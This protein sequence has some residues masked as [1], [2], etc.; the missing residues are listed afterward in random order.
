MKNK[1][2]KKNYRNS[3]KVILIFSSM[4]FFVLAVT[5]LIVGVLMYLIFQRDTLNITSAET[6]GSM[7]IFFLVASIILGTVIAA[8]TAR[9]FLKNIDNIIEGMNDL[10]SGNYEVRV[11]AVQSGMTKELID[12]FNLLADELENTKTLRSDFVNDFAHEFKTPIVSL[13]GFAKLLKNPNLTDEERTEYLKIIEEEAN[14]LSVMSTNS[15]NLT[16]VEKQ[17]ILTEKTQ[18]NLSEQIRNCV[19]LLE[20]KWSEKNL[21]L[22][23]DLEEISVFANEEMLKQ[24]F[25][26]LIDNAVKF[27]YENK[28]LKLKLYKKE[29]KVVFSIR[30]YGLAISD[31]DKEKIFT[32]FYR[33]ENSMGI[34][35]TGVGLAIVKKIVELHK[36]EILLHNESDFTEFEVAIPSFE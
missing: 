2:K 28:E 5:M 22:D 20:K 16:R 3:S 10:A 1:V 19:L 23:L 13:L 12:T 29:D 14:R 17:T 33:A 9:I 34:E 8:T 31:A 26:N 24:V 15:L 7:V 35:G 36:G 11:P 25:I 4:V 6:V 27:S 18:F 30:N 32:R 21:E